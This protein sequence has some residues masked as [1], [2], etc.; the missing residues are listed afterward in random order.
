MDPPMVEIKFTK[1]WDAQAHGEEN[2]CLEAENCV[3]GVDTFVIRGSVQAAGVNNPHIFR[4][5]KEYAHGTVSV[6]RGIKVYTFWSVP[7]VDAVVQENGQ[8]Y[9]QRFG[10][11]SASTS[12]SVTVNQDNVS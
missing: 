6:G 11:I 12:S 3:D 1:D 4:G 10:V 8:N 7:F 5:I 9:L 2:L